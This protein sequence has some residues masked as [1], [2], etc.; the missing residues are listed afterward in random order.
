M[1]PAPWT[2][3]R[4]LAQDLAGP[5]SGFRYGDRDG[6]ERSLQAANS[7]AAELFREARFRQPPLREHQITAT[8]ADAEGTAGGQTSSGQSIQ[9]RRTQV[10]YLNM[11]FRM[12]ER[13]LPWPYPASLGLESR[14]PSFVIVN[15]R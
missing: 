9:V 13:E 2:A 7:H 5:L 8:E 1:A 3:F 6:Y 11:R 4:H 15:Q 14:A 12:S 10:A